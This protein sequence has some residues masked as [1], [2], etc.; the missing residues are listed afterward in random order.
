MLSTGESFPSQDE[1]SSRA[2]AVP[3]CPI[4]ELGE[5]LTSG[6]VAYLEVGILDGA[7]F[8]VLA[9]ID[10]TFTSTSSIG[11]P[12]PVQTASFASGTHTQVRLGVPIVS[13]PSYLNLLVLGLSSS[14]E[15]LCQSRLSVAVA[16][17][18][19]YSSVWDRVVVPV[20]G[21][22]DGRYGSH[23]RTSLAL[24]G[25]GTGTVY[26]RK[27]GDFYGDE[28]DPHLHYDLGYL[29]MAGIPGVIMVE[30]VNDAFGVDGVGQLDIVP[31]YLDQ[32]SDPRS[33]WLAPIAEAYIYNDSSHG[34]YGAAVESLSPDDLVRDG[35]H[36]Q[37]PAGYGQTIRVN[38]GLRSFDL[39][40]T[41]TPYVYVRELEAAIRLEPTELAPNTYEQH[42]LSQ[43][44]VDYQAVAGDLVFLDF[45][46]GAVAAYASFTDNQSND[47]RI[48]TDPEHWDS[49]K[50]RGVV[51][52]PWFQ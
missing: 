16:A 21:T 34:R 41:V 10:P 1:A 11:R 28:R 31:D 45:E 13:N 37:L 26:F 32:G 36:L 23:F 27:R 29:G 6:Q 20:A 25:F 46:G 7:W 39:P 8:L 15:A 33:D 50:V 30:D 40:V 17:H 3:E 44:L 18:V 42:M 19:G 5:P 24:R 9:S 14:G 51:S 12:I 4:G 2:G 38:V 47:H 35:L 48:V 52:Y 43:L 22:V 49:E